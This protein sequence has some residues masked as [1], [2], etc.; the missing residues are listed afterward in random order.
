M[1]Y[2]TNPA[3]KAFAIQQDKAE[4]ESESSEPTQQETAMN[5]LHKAFRAH[6]HIDRIFT[7]EAGK[8][9]RWPLQ[10]V[11]KKTK[12]IVHHTATQ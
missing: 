8:L 5:Y 9:L 1:R 6:V 3:Y 4:E 11:K 10:Y 2:T 7:K 12:L